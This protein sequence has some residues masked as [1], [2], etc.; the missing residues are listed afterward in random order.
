MNKEQKAVAIDEITGYLQ[1]ATAVYLTDFQGLSVAQSN[2]LRKEFRAAGVEFKVVKNTLL[3]RAMQGIGGYDEVFGYL[4]GATA[5][6]LTNDPA[7]PAKILKKFIAA[8]EEKP[9]FKGAYVGGAVFSDKQ[10]ETLT[11]LKSKDELVGDIIGL[12]LA[13]ASNVVGA[14]QSQGAN[15]M[16][17]LKTL[18]EREN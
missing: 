13:P 15:I 8:N 3:Q 16:G 6:A 5:I 9:K 2:E 17:I 11:T 1:N 7:T 18:S 14:L 4:H 12:L 10:L